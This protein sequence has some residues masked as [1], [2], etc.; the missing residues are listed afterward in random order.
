MRQIE[1]EEEFK[2]P[3]PEFNEKEDGVPGWE[4]HLRNL[5]TFKSLLV[6]GKIELAGNF[7]GKIENSATMLNYLWSNP[8]MMV[9]MIDYLA[10][11]D[12]LNRLGLK[13]VLN[14]YEVNEKYILEHVNISSLI[15][16]KEIGVITKY[17][18]FKECER[19]GD[20]SI[21][22]NIKYLKDILGFGT[23][24]YDMI[25]TLIETGIMT[26]AM[27]DQCLEGND[28]ERWANC[29]LN[30]APEINERVFPQSLWLKNNGKP[31]YEADIYGGRS[32]LISKSKGEYQQQMIVMYLQF[33]PTNFFEYI[34]VL[35]PTNIKKLNQMMPEGPANEWD[36]GWIGSGIET[37]LVLDRESIGNRMVEANGSVVNEFGDRTLRDPSSLT[38]AE[39]LKIQEIKKEWAEERVFIKELAKKDKLSYALISNLNTSDL[40][41]IRSYRDIKNKTLKD[42]YL[43]GWKQ[44]P[45]T[46]RGINHNENQQLLGNPEE[47]KELILKSVHWADYLKLGDRLNEARDIIHNN[48]SDIN[49]K[50]VFSLIFNRKIDLK[51]Q[52]AENLC[53]LENLLNGKWAALQTD[54]W[55]NDYG[56]Q[57]VVEQLKIPTEEL[58]QAVQIVNQMLTAIKSGAF[59]IIDHKIISWLMTSMYSLDKYQ[60]IKQYIS[61]AQ[62]KNPA[63]FSLNLN[64]GEVQFEVLGNRDVSAFRVGLETDCCQRL[65]GAGEE[66]AIDSFINELAGV[67]L[68]KV[69]GRIL[70][71]SYFHYVPKDNGFILDNVEWNEKEVEKL[72]WGELQLTAI[73]AQY[74]AKIKELNPQIKYF[75]C[76]TEYNKIDN[77]LFGKMKLDEDPRHFEVEEPYSDW[78]EEE[79]LDLLKPSPVLLTMALQ[80]KSLA[81]KMKLMTKVSSL[82]D[83]EETMIRLAWYRSISKLNSVL[84]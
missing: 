34:K 10:Q 79:S 44:D 46:I 4:M 64:L 71:Q 72:G 1:L 47:V 6:S 16:L 37:L 50:F 24:H 33:N 62:D 49:G 66:A 41:Q 81:S 15:K 35:T 20:L 29:L 68:C 52:Y 55:Y 39:L 53:V 61:I 7:L 38:E 80:R 42:M 74:A 36:G 58:K 13:A 27:L 3:I 69:G 63:L 75:S 30:N 43:G 78:N 31:Y 12:A 5:E 25:V 14:T 56:S 57:H 28:I 67:L 48:E 17:L 59:P 54:N 19:R 21:Y 60:E 84:R 77:S 32:G 8:E 2:P 82:S 26:S 65:G 45:R 23:K 9:K 83:S 40:K 11:F 18:L 76:G 70:G 22:R 51:Q 73:Y